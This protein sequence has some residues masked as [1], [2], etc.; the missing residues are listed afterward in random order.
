MLHCGAMCLTLS[1]KMIGELWMRTLDAPLTGRVT[2]TNP[3]SSPVI[4]Q[5]NELPSFQQD[6]NLKLIKNCDANYIEESFN[7]GK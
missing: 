7:T 1:L 5:N 3:V 4:C 6:H 2:A